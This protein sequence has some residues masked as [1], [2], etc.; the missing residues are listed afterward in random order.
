MACIQASCYFGC[1]WDGCTSS[2]R[3]VDC[4]SVLRHMYLMHGFG[5]RGHIYCGIDD[6]Q[7]VSSTTGSYRKHIERKHNALLLTDRGMTVLNSGDSS[8]VCDEDGSVDHAVDI[9]G[10]TAASEINV[11]EMLTQLSRLV[12][13]FGLRIREQYLLPK[14]TFV[15][16]MSDVRDILTCYQGYISDIVKGS[17]DNAPAD[18]DLSFMDDNCVLNSI[19]NSVVTETQLKKNCK[20]L[21]GL[22]EPEEITLGVNTQTN[23][24]DTYQYVSVVKT[25]KHYLEHEDVW[26]SI[27]VNRVKYDGVL[28]DYTDGHIFTEHAFFGANPNAIRLHFYVDELEVCNPLG[29]ARSKHKITA[30]YYYVGNIEKNYS[31]SL[32]CIH[33]AIL[34][35]SY[36]V[37]QYTIEKI[38]ERLVM[39]LKL[40]ET[41]GVLVEANGI[42]VQVFASMATL[43]G[44]NLASHQL[45]GFRMC[46][47]S[48]R[49][50][51]HCMVCYDNI[52]KHFSETDACFPVLR[53][54]AGHVSHVKSV[55]VDRSLSSVYGVAGLSALHSLNSFNP[56]TCLPPDCMHDVLEGVVPL[57]LTSVLRTLICNQVISVGLVNDRLLRMKLTSSDRVNAPPLLPQNFPAKGLLGT[58]SQIWIFLRILPFVIGDLVAEDNEV[59]EVYLLLRHI[60]DIVFAPAVHETWLPVLDQAISDHNRLLVNLCGAHLTPK[61]HFLVHYPRMIASFGPLRHL[62]C[63]R[64]EAYHRYLKELASTI[65]NFR[66]ISKT[67]ADR[68]QMKTCFEQA[69]SRCME[70]A[71]ECCEVK[72]SVV[73]SALPGCIQ[74]SITSFFGCEHSDMILQVSSFENR[75]V[76]YSLNH[77]FVIDVVG[78]DIPV[79]IQVRHLL[80]REGLWCIVG[81]LY[82]CDAYYR[83]YHAYSIVDKG[84]WIVTAAGF[85]K[86]FHS[87]QP[88]LVFL[89]G[90]EC[91]LIALRHKLLPLLK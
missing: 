81:R 78:E 80:S 55:L 1:P 8:A 91:K 66:N 19:W 28:Y 52:G 61:C 43:S 88:Y 22:I 4:K 2:S 51:R 31:S 30:V 86:D 21:L 62:W 75:G 90:K 38:F 65:G 40:L 76:T 73:V 85:E 89:D 83:H 56:V 84:E 47:N 49:I 23:K 27:S 10:D 50:C 82:I 17:G 77:Y 44:D 9:S 68:N 5:E 16:I 59:W 48:G 29:S 20:S 13:L 32:R 7:D 12:L 34:A 42:K 71:A 15:S 39:E 58:A 74:N 33:V 63:M 14:S 53:T 79:F 6:C 45:G 60:C 57:C 70:P 35:R 37:K 54:S 36:L 46:F 72:D 25:L 26:E 64:F 3:F 18:C 67:L 24:K 87:Y 11:D 69:G 41:D